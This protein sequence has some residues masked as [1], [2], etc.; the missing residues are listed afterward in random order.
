MTFVWAFVVG[1]LLCAL[2]QLV[3]D[4][5]SWAPGQVLVLFVVL[6][7]FFGG[8]GLYGKLVQFAGAG[9]TVPL[10]GFGYTMVEGIN[11]AVQ[12]KG[13]LGLLTGGLTAAA[14]GIKS[15]VLFGLTAALIFRPKA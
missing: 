15:A 11:Q 9:A 10:P 2:A 3:M 4:G 12:H 1:G 6:G 7:A 8:I 13:V 14:G 5:L